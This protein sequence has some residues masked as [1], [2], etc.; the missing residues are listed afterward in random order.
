MDGDVH[1]KFLYHTQNR[2]HPAE[3]HETRDEARRSIFK[4]IE[5]FDNRNRIHS[6]LGGVSAERY[7]QIKNVA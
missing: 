6:V 5:I 7:E 1:R 2:P 3:R 4:Y